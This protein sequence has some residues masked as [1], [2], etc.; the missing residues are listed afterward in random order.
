MQAVISYSINNHICLRVVVVVSMSKTLF[1]SLLEGWLTCTSAA[2]AG[3]GCSRLVGVPLLGLIVAK[4]TWQSIVART[5]GGH[6]FH[7]GESIPVEVILSSAHAA[8]KFGDEVG[9]IFIHAHSTHFI[10]TRSGALSLSY[11]ASLMN[12]CYL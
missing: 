3:A 1:V 8:Q 11:T 2:H 4:V 6:R 12:T 5:R 10:G 9:A 7:I